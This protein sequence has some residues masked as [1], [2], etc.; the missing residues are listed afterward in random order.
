MF[1]KLS[2]PA[3]KQ[4]RQEVIG[5]KVT[6][7]ATSDKLVAQNVTETEKSDLSP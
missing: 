5:Q 1:Q 4:R 2:H 6:K 7:N 3:A